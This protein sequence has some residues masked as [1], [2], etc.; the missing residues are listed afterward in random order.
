[1]E[2]AR[3]LCPWD[4]PGKNPGLKKN[5]FPGYLPDPR[6]EPM[7]LAYVVIYTLN[8]ESKEV[9]FYISA[10]IIWEWLPETLFRSFL[11]LQPN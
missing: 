9:S 7:S 11:R 8:Q 3:L 5:P 6:I 4:S 1:M 2:P 10:V